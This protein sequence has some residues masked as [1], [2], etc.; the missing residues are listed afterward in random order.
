MAKQT[1][2]IGTVAN[3]GTGTPNRDAWDMVND[4][5]TELYDGK[6]ALDADLTAIAALSPTNDDI[7]QRKSGAWT[8]RTIAQ[9]A[10][11]LQTPFDSRYQALDADLTAIAGLSATNDD[12]IQRKSG[13][14]A[15]RTVAQVSADLEAQWPVAFVVA[16]PAPVEGD[17]YQLTGGSFDVNG[18]QPENDVWHLGFNMDEGGGL[19]DLTKAAIFISWES[20]YYLGGNGTGVRVTEWH[21]QTKGPDPADTIRPISVAMPWAASDRTSSGITFRQDNV[22]FVDYG[23]TAKVQMNW[24]TGGISLESGVK[25]VSD[26]N[27]VPFA[28]MKNAA[29]NAFLN[30]PYVDSNDQLLVSQS[31]QC[32]PG[33]TAT[34]NS[35]HT[36]GFTGTFADGDSLLNTFWSGSATGSVFVHN[37]AGNATFRVIDGMQNTAN[38]AN[39]MAV[40]HIWCGGTSAGNAWT[41]YSNGTNNWSVGFLNT[42]DDSFVISNSYWLAESNIGESLTANAAIRID[43][44]TREIRSYGGIELVDAN[45]KLGTTTGTKIGTATSQKLGFWNATPIVQPTTGVAAAVFAANSGTAVNDASTFD[46]YTLLQVVKA[47]R[48]AGLLA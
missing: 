44:T 47:L 23:N 7:V 35:V 25:F 28:Q 4:N 19:V 6:Q 33:G 3:D 8:N 20:N 48:N 10:T 24:T 43:R 38:T 11:D 9:V 21:L 31:I 12:F 13:A 34:A 17:L 41:N 30:L 14:W 27:N 16:D 22:T 2:D 26:N 15:N 39:A 40:E 1:I 37:K 42:D 5:F 46:G 45:L 32:Q 36:L 18:V 29:D